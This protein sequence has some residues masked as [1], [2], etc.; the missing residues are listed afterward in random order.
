M[1]ESLRDLPPDVREVITARI[2]LVVRGINIEPGVVDNT[3]YAP[4][5]VNLGV[6]NDQFR[7]IVVSKTILLRNAR[8]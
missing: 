1:T 7:R 3:V 2:W 6:I 8:I 4:G 5:N